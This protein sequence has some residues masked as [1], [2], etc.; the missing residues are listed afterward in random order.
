MF[1]GWERDDW[2]Y[3]FGGMM[4]VSSTAW[5][6]SATMLNLRQLMVA[7][8]PRK[9]SLRYTKEILLYALLVI[10]TLGILMTLVYDGG[11]L[12]KAIVPKVILW[13]P[14]PVS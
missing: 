1:E 4:A 12:L 6:V 8:L 9:K 3:L 11:A 10:C 14:T 13:M 7:S 2:L 5:M